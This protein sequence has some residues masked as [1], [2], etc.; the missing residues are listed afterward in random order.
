[1]S[2]LALKFVVSQRDR[3]SGEF[4]DWGELE[5][6][7]QPRVGEFIKRE[8]DGAL[9]AFL[10]IAVL[11][12]DGQAAGEIWVESRGALADLKK[13]NGSASFGFLGA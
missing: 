11:H 3:K 10:V 7:S 6:A 8:M 2:T 4:T 9:H 5:F 12:S 1:M 13:P